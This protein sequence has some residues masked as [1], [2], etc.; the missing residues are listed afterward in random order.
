MFRDF[1][2]SVFGSV[3]DPPISAETLCLFVAYLHKLK[4]APKT[5]STYISAIGYVHKML[6]FPDPSN[7]FMVSRLI[8][9][10][11]RARP[12]FDIRLPITLSILDKLIDALEHTA[13]NW[14]DIILFKAMYLFAFYTFARI[15]EIT[16]NGATTDHV[17]QF[18]DISLQN[19]GHHLAVTVTFRRYKHNLTGAPH[20]ITFSRGYSTHDPVMALQEYIKLRGTS[21]GPLFCF[22]SGEPVK[23][24]T[25]DTLLHKTLQ[26]CRLDSTRYKGHSFRIG[27][28]SFR[29]EQGD[30]DSQ[31]RA[32]GRWK[33][34]AFLKYIR[35]YNS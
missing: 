28:A 35:T 2:S 33:G 30:S 6:N 12:S 24:H 27:A 31:I 16:A 17:V 11:Y 20:S 4:R 8:A 25:F 7:S 18:E 26:F 9:G 22:V 19:T 29:S 34:N 32:L 10:S 1:S 14:F 23:R 13:S 21:N 5:I 3:A 15:G